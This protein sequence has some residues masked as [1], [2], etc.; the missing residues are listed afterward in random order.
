MQ[1]L[2]PEASSRHAELGPLNEIVAQI[3]SLEGQKKI[4]RGGRYNYLCHGSPIYLAAIFFRHA[5]KQNPIIIPLSLMALI[6]LVTTD[7]K[8]M[9][10]LYFGNADKIGGV[11]S[12]QVPVSGRFGKPSSCDDW[13]YRHVVCDAAYP[14]LANGIP[15]H[16]SFR[17]HSSG[18]AT[19]LS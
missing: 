13:R 7:Q 8:P 2:Y 12:P 4:I 5:I 15:R 16:G 10:S 3:E 17:I 6:K 11:I 1:S 19:R 14:V 18:L 9:F